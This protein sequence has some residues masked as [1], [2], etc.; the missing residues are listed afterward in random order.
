[1]TELYQKIEEIVS[2]KHISNSLYIRHAYSRKVD[3][4]LQGVPSVII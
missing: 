1:M 2:K 4:L 3:P